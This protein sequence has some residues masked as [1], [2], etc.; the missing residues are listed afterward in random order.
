MLSVPFCVWWNI[1]AASV[2]IS[3]ISDCLRQLR[4]YGPAL[5]QYRKHCILQGGVFFLPVGVDKEKL[6][7]VL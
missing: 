3:A 2:K 6:D 1:T 7:G 5:C 4:P